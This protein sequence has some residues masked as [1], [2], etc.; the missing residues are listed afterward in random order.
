MPRRG[1]AAIRPR[2]ICNQCRADG[3]TRSH[4][5]SRSGNHIDT[6]GCC[7]CAAE[8]QGTR[9]AKKTAL[10]VV[11]RRNPQTRLRPRLGKRRRAKEGLDSE[12]P[13]ASVWRLRLLALDCTQQSIARHDSLRSPNTTSARNASPCAK[14]L[15][16][17]RLDVRD[18]A[19]AA[20]R[21]S[22]IWAQM[23]EAPDSSVSTRR[24][25]PDHANNLFVI[26]RRC[27]FARRPDK[28][29]PVL[30]R[31]AHPSIRGSVDTAPLPACTPLRLSRNEGCLRGA[32]PRLVRFQCGSPWTTRPL[33]GAAGSQPAVYK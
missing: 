14:R 33:L 12:R 11:A 25:L 29:Q 8:Q 7:V 9:P 1:T 16:A 28:S 31:R 20:Q 21:Q 19:V 4:S 5:S 15:G 23:D 10:R 17:K 13:R 6:G 22:L 26:T 3:A 27:L 32:H 30:V 2:S 18:S 24:K